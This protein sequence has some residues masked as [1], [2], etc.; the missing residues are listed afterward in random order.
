MA[1]LSVRACG[2]PDDAVQWSPL[3]EVR[4]A[5]NTRVARSSPAFRTE[6]SSDRQTLPQR[7]CF[8]Q[9]GQRSAVSGVACQ[10]RFEQRSL[11]P[12]IMT[13]RV[14][15]LGQCPSRSIPS[16]ALP[17]QRLG[18]HLDG[19]CCGERPS[20]RSNSL[21]TRVRFDLPS[22]L[23]PPAR[24]CRGFAARPQASP[25]PALTLAPVRGTL[26]AMLLSGAVDLA[27]VAR[28]AQV[29]HLPTIVDDTLDLPKIVHPR[30]RLPGTRPP[31]R[32]VRQPIR[33]SRPPAATTGS[34]L[35]S[36]GPSFCRR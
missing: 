31:R 25:V 23:A 7:H 15:S 10:L 22:T 32:P 27:A 24:A 3:V 29:K 19:Q 2:D 1:A 8:Q 5:T 6:R 16:V 36:P 20:A 9:R 21:A 33:R 12:A 35:L 30:A 28:S 4:F 18:R 26:F 11:G 17:Q 34:E 13:T 14:V